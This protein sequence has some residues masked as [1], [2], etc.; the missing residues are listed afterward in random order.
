MM[1]RYVGYPTFMSDIN[2]SAR[3][4]TQRLVAIA[5]F[6]SRLSDDSHYKAYRLTFQCSAS[7]SKTW[8]FCV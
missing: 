8:L 2:L 6:Y 4:S 5:V 3:S 1:M 7:R